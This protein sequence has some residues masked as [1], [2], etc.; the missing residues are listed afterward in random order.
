[1]QRDVK[2][3]ADRLKDLGFGDDWEDF[4]APLSKTLKDGDDTKIIMKTGNWDRSISFVINIEKHAGELSFPSYRGTFIQVPEFKHS[5][6]NGIDSEVVE[7]LMHHLD[8]KTDVAKLEQRLEKTGRGNPA[9]ISSYHKALANMVM[10]AAT[11]DGKVISDALKI[12]YFIGTPYEQRYVSPELKASHVNDRTFYADTA[13]AF[14]RQEATNLLEGRA[15]LKTYLDNDGSKQKDWFRTLPDSDQA[16]RKNILFSGWQHIISNYD[17]ASVIKTLP[18]DFKTKEERVEFIRQLQRGDL[19]EIT[20]PKIGMAATYFIEANPQTKSI[21][22]YDEKMKPVS[23]K[24]MLLD[25][26][27]TNKKIKGKHL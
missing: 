23:R 3:I 22:I 8:W 6:M 17:L 12:R 26:K 7:A 25:C 24:E 20:I 13:F 19:C 1:M 15:V 16:D 18:L 10:L 21:N 4:I 11:E 27:A 5:V 14:T 9:L 2:Q